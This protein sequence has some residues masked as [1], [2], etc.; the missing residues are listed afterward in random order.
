V[1]QFRESKKLVADS[2]FAFHFSETRGGDF[3]AAAWARVRAVEEEKFLPAAAASLESRPSSSTF[4]AV[5]GLTQA[6]MDAGL[7]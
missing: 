1:R 3:L 4:S 2:G 7:E 5:A 6:F